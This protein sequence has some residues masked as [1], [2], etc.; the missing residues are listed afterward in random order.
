MR[1]DLWSRLF[2][3]VREGTLFAYR[4]VVELLAPTRLLRCIQLCV[5]AQALAHLDSGDL[6][7]PTLCAANLA[8]ADYP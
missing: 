8:T 6:N 4:R 1:G 7:L 5:L 2:T 3:Y